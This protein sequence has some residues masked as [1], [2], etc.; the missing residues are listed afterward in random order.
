MIK[1]FSLFIFLCGLNNN[2]D[3]KV[4]CVGEIFFLIKILFPVPVLFLFFY[5][6]KCSNRKIQH[7]VLISYI[8]IFLK[9]CLIWCHF[10]LKSSS[11]V[12]FKTY[13]VWEAARV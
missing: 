2:V 8:C 9:L 13:A 12:S 4:S 6:K 3:V 10:L 7:F 1:I 5:P 11:W